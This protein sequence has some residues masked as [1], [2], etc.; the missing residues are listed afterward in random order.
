VTRKLVGV[1]GVFARRSGAG[2]AAGG[3]EPSRLA[4]TLVLY[5]ERR[6]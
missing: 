6:H 2:I 3:F 1:S 4:K 5:V